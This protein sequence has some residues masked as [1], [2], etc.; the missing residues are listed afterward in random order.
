MECK[1]WVYV[2]KQDEIETP[3]MELMEEMN[4][5]LSQLKEKNALLQEEVEQD[6]ASWSALPAG[7]V[8]IIC[9]F[10]TQ[11]PVLSLEL[12]TL[13]NSL[14]DDQIQE[15]LLA[16]NA[17]NERMEERL[18]TL[19]S[20][21]APPQLSDK[22]IKAADLKLEK[23]RKEWRTRKRLFSDMWG[24]VTEN[25][26]GSIEEFRESVGIETDESAGVNINDDPLKGLT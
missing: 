2:A 23:M 5:Q 20:G 10:I 22:E 11:A 6:P 13:N 17:E 18:A 21:D 14:T 16:L 24:T 4:V 7:H 12:S 9:S 25:V 15:K 1:Q 19:R 8:L 3:S 26:P